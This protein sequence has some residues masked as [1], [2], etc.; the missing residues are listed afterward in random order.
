MNM[1]NFFTKLFNRQSPSVIGLDIGT[2]SIKV[3]QLSRKNGR[4]I[5]ET[6]GELSLGPYAKGSVGEATNLPLDKVIEAIN[7][8]LI[9]KEVNITSRVAG[10]SI[11][12]ASSLVSVIDFPVVPI[13]ELSNMV[14]LEA[15]K[16]IPVPMSEVVIDWSLIPQDKN[17]ESDPNQ[18]MGPDGRP[19][20][21][22]LEVLVVALHNSTI[23]KYKKITTQSGLQADFFEIEIFSTMR[24]VLDQDVA[25][26]MILD[27]GAMTTKIYIVEKGILRASHTI[28]N[29]SYN[30]S[31]ALSKAL[32]ISF[33]EAEIMKREKG[34]SLSPENIGIKDVITVTLDYI[35]S[36]ANRVVLAYE[37]KYNKNV[38]KVFLVGGGSAL[39]GIKDVAQKSFQTEV[40]SGDP[41]SKVVTPAF[42]EDILRQTGPQFTVA[43]GLAL[44]KLQEVE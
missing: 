36:E 20:P 33:A 16:Y 19:I 37:K 31:Q 30:I 41:F 40:I 39:I 29:G 26:V 1:A 38:S 42:L 14:P 9:E 27:M 3:V 17:P 12:F 5:L 4:A 10:L 24:S 7:D 25:P 18:K 23:D 34:L 13:K 32:G 11:P 43:V 8:I 2:S 35:F 21:P 15:R 6:Y 28:N 44:R 22:R